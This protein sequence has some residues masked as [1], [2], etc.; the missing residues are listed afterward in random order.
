MVT[1]PKCNW[2]V[3]M[4]REQYKRVRQ[5]IIQTVLMTDMSKH[6]IELGSITSRQSDDEFNPTE[7]KDKELLI[8]FMFHL[9]DISNPTKPWELCKLWTDLLFVEFFQQGDLEE[10]NGFP[11]SQ[12]YDRKTTNIAQSQLGFID[13]II[14][15]AFAPVMKIFPNIAH[16]ETCIESNKS[17][18]KSQI[19]AYEE[20]KDKG[21]H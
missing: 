3:K 2:A 14:K 11:I 9:A 18:W 21:N 16:L 13:F 20:E 17:N 1:D 19:D 15:P 4:T 10:M 7:S 5:V 6:F 8:K 12:F